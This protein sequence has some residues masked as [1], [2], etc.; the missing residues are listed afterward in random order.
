MDLSVVLTSAAVSA[1]V[2]GLFTFVSQGLERRARQREFLLKTAAEWATKHLEE[3]LALAKVK[4]G[5][6]AI[7]GLGILTYRYHQ[8]LLSLMKSGKLPPGMQ[9]DYEEWVRQSQ[10]PS[11][12]DTDA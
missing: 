10:S 12:E 9:P 6:T 8:Q 2:S 3:G 4:G 5:R 11:V 1:V 7:P